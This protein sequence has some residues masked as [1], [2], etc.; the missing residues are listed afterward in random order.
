MLKVKVI[1]GKSYKVLAPNTSHGLNIG[2]VVTAEAAIA[3]TLA[4]QKRAVEQ[5]YKAE[6]WLIVET[7][8]KR[9]FDESGEF[10][11]EGEHSEVIAIVK[12]D[13]TV[14]YK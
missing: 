9:V 6:R 10:V 7:K 11:R 8:W 2:F 13:G 4:S 3:R 5:G 12:D 1:E 14:E